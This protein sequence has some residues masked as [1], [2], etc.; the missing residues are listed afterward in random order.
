MWRSSWRELGESTSAKK[1]F[2]KKVI[3][4]KKNSE[5]GSGA[6]FALG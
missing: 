4:R 5:H 1:T 2:S 3:V 6:K